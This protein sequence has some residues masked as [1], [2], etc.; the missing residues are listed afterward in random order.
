MTRIGFGTASLGRSVPARERL[1]V[2]ETAYECGLRHFDTAPLYGSGSAEQALGRFGHRD[3]LTIATKVGIR[4]ARVPRL[5]KPRGGLFAP[6]DV[7]KSLAGSLRRLRTSY[8]DILLLHE[9]TPDA[10][11]DALL[12]TLDAIVR[13]GDARRVGIATSL[14][15]SERI[16]AAAGAFPEVV[17]VAARHEPPPLDGRMLILHSAIVGGQGVRATAERRPDAVVLFG[18]RNVAHVRETATAAASLL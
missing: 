2:I 18:S 11:G 9:V 8:V 16:L 10:I 5:T 14:P 4:P 17:Q 3:E 6:A 15:S 7:R 13:A 12:E 1:R